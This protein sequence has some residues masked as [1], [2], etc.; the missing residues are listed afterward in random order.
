MK[1]KEPKS[2]F[3]EITIAGRKIGLGYPTFI[4]AELSGN[5]HQKY[6]EAEELVREAAKAGVDAI[7]LQ[8]YT[9]DTITINSNKPPFI[10]VNKDNPKDW[11][12]KTLYELYQ[13]A[14]TPWDWQPKLKKVAEDLGMVLFSTP[15]DETAV[16]FLEGMGVPCYKVASY[17]ATHIP[18]LKKIAA[19]HKP[20]IISIGFAT[21]EEVSEA[22]DTLKSGGVHD[23]A[24]LHCVTQYADKPDLSS[25]NLLTIADI[26]E[27]FGVVSGFSDNNAGTKA[28]ILAAAAGASIIEK[29]LILSK[30]S[31]GPDAQF[32]LEPAEMKAMVDQIR[33]DEKMLGQVHFGPNNASEEDN[34]RYRRSVFVAKNI[35]KG[36]KFTRENIR[37][38]RPADGL[39]PRDFEQVLGKTA[40]TDIELGTPLSWDLIQK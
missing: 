33:Q 22:V 11:K 28:P 34:R 29:H 16:D 15:F 4:V 20:V 39:P 7:K 8:T 2:S 12:G 32:S 6:E 9:P 38:I 14:Y 3:P 37:V 27:R 19:T 31:G 24:V 21:L 10:V 36:D 26:R 1:E 30:S 13:G 35:K 23:I 25:I 40:A 18:L 5:H 17:E